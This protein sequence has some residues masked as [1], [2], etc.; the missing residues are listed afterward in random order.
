MSVHGVILAYDYW[1]HE[2]IN[3]DALGAENVSSIKSIASNKYILT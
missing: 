3:N 2:A 1:I